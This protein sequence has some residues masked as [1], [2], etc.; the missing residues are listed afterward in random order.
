MIEKR[1]SSNRKIMTFRINARIL[2]PSKLNSY[3]LIKLTEPSGIRRRA[4][5]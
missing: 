5:S 3:W 1:K 4:I 2:K